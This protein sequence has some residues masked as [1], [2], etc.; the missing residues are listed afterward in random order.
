MYIRS[1]DSLITVTFDAVGGKF[2]DGQ[3]I[4]SQKT[5]ANSYINEP[6]APVRDGYTFICWSK[7]NTEKIMLPSI[8]PINGFKLVSQTRQLLGCQ[9]AVNTSP[10]IPSALSIP[11]PKIFVIFLSLLY[12]PAKAYPFA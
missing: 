1:G 9:R 11:M 6:N 2:A 7:S 4:M 3:S 5:S 12:Q 8:S 10:S